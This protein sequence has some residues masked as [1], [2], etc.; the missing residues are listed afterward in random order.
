MKYFL[1]IFLASFTIFGC[2]KEKTYTKKI[3]HKWQHVNDDF[4]FTDGT[5]DLSSGSLDAE[6]WSFNNGLLEKNYSNGNT[7]YDYTIEND[8]L[9]TKGQGNIVGFDFTYT[10]ESITDEKMVLLY[11]LTNDAGEK[12]GELNMNFKR[13]D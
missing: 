2:S 1:I 3:Q 6:Y 11:M 12:N 8:Q 9:K 13:A 5:P 10:I 4:K 7:T